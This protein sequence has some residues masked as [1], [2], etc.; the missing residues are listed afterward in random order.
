M[1]EQWNANVYQQSYSFVWQYGKD[2]LGMLDPQ[3]GERILDVGC[4]TGQL[5]AEIAQTGAEVLGIDASEAMVAQARGNFPELRFEQRDVRDLPFQA[6]FDGVF[7]NAVLHWVQPPERAAACMS[8]AL[9]PGGRLVVEMG[10][11]GNIA[12]IVRAAEAAWNSIGEGPPPGLPWYYPATGEYASLLE[13]NGLE[14]TVAMLFDRPTP[15]EAGSEG[16]ARWYEMFGGHWLNRLST[17]KR[18]AFLAE[19]GRQAAPRLL[20]DG[21]WMADYR[22]LRVMARKP[23]SIGSR[24]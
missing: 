3:P 12:E 10:G 6:E 2:L 15:L 8:R 21:T 17:E 16:L 11:R 1:S 18:T 19:A 20:Q 7:S 4:G 23:A 14:V 5:T 24:E 22:R 13:S 9:K